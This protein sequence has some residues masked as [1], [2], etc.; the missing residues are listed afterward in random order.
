MLSLTYSLAQLFGVTEES[1][2]RQTN[3]MMNYILLN[4]K[5]IV[6][7]P[8]KKDYPRIAREFNNSGR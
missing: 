5:Y 3:R 2:L 1:F 4:M 7:W 6:Q 8:E